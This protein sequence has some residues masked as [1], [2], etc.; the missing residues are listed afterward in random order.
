MLVRLRFILRK[1]LYS[2]RLG[3][4]ARLLAVAAFV[5]ILSPAAASGAE[6]ASS[7]QLTV[8]VSLTG[9]GTGSVSSD[10]AGISCP[11]VCSAQF[12]DGTLVRLMAEADPGSKLGGFT[13]SGTTCPGLGVGPPTPGIRYCQFFL[14]ASTGNVSV[15]M[16]FGLKPPCVVPRIEGRTVSYAI[17]QTAKNHCLGSIAHAFSRKVKKGR[18]ISQRPKA[19]S[20]LPN[21]ATVNFLVSKGRRLQSVR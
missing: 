18:V 4:G 5:L 1:R 2:F 20:R 7:A 15:Q 21:G 19:G 8:T 16:T 13:T 14:D 10:P 11:T 6:R 17:R 3:S 12:A 9:T